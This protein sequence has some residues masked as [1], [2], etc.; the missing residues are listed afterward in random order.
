MLRLKKL[1]HSTDLVSD[2]VQALEAIR[3]KRYDVVLM[4]L[5]LPGMDGIQTA[6]AIFKEWPSGERP[7]IIALTADD[8][9]QV[10]QRC[11]EAG[12]D[13][14]L[15]KPFDVQALGTVLKRH[16]GAVV[17]GAATHGTGW[18]AG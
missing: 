16:R 18:V 5:R 12:M 13:G 8:D 4:D 15:C 17:P 10:K 3:E 9:A 7:R 11:L 14:V 2:G 6:R 1:G